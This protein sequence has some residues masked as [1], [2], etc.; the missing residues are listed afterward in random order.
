MSYILQFQA[1]DMNLFS[2]NVKSE[3]VS[4]YIQTVAKIIITIYSYML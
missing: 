3:I 1:Q 4:F 2:I